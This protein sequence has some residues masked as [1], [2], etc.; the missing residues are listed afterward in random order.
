MSKMDIVFYGSAVLC[1]VSFILF[2][3]QI[4]A[5]LR[6][7][8]PVAPAGGLG[9]ARPQAFDVREAL[10]E[11][12]K[13]VQSFAKAGPIASAAALCVFFALICVL[14]SGLVKIG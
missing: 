7:P 4:V 11:M 3:W 8:K 9:D 5:Q 13:L 1:V 14:S 10:E 2:A 6:H 12:G